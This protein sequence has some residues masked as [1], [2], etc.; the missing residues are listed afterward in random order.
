MLGS[1]IAVV[2]PEIVVA[3]KAPSTSLTLTFRSHGFRLFGART[4]WKK[5][6]QSSAADAKRRVRGLD[7]IISMILH[8]GDETVCTACRVNYDRPSSPSWIIDELIEPDL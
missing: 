3:S 8:A 7:L 6:F 1:L 4:F 2:N 5:Y